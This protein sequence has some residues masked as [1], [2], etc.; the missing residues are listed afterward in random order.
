MIPIIQ[1]IISYSALRSY[2]KDVSLAAQQ[3]F[4]DSGKIPFQMA[5]P[6]THVG[7]EIECELIT[8]GTN[9]VPFGWQVKTDDSLRDNGVEFVTFPIR[10][11]N[12][13]YALYALEKWAHEKNPQHR[14]SERTSVHIHMN[15]RRLNV[16][17]LWSFM[18]I[19]LVVEKLMYVYAGAGRHNNIFCVPIKD[20]SLWQE[21]AVIHT[22][23]ENQEYEDAL[24]TLINE[25][26][27]YTGLNTLPLSTLGTVEFRQMPGT[28]DVPRLIKWINIIQSMKRATYRYRSS[29]IITM[30]EDMN[31]I[32]TY[33]HFLQDI[34]GEHASALHMPHTNDLM[35]QSVIFI[36]EFIAFGKSLTHQYQTPTTEAQEI[37]FIT[38]DMTQY[39][40]QLGWLIA[41][42]TSSK[43]AKSIRKS[44][45][46][47]RIGEDELY[48]AISRRQRQRPRVTMTD[49][50]D[51]D[52]QME[53][54]MRA[55]RTIR[56]R[57]PTFAET[58][59]ATTFFTTPTEERD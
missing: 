28:F 9:A 31:S 25:W 24:E 26:R 52:S 45:D 13:S 27:K 36:K 15:M 6:A 54:L 23:I 35:E 41:P 22:M 49:P 21:L 59:G 38:S 48:S 4:T 34:F 14:F 18:L 2:E 19:Y 46:A 37:S 42:K 16:E 1:D 43:E 55:P 29:E 30:I 56:P 58:L 20:S 12:I 47:L 50:I 8:T 51:I 32:S 3:F 39:L 7:I 10:D 53:A 33:A 11:T 40:V 17:Q 44:L 5:D 57:P